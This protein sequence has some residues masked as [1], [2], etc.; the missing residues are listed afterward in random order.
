MVLK[1]KKWSNYIYGGEF[2]Y[3]KKKKEEEGKKKRKEKKKRRGRGGIQALPS[4]LSAPHIIELR[5]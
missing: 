1:K 5:Y 2:W 3:E 4:T